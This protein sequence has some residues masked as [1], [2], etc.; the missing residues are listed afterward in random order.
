MATGPLGYLS[1]LLHGH[2]P[3][4][5]HPE[6]ED[7]L[8][9]RWLVE[10]LIECY[11]PL[12]AMLEGRAGRRAGGRIT[13]SLSPTL[14][15][16][17]ADPLLKE[18]LV[19]RVERLLDLA[20]ADVARYRDDARI[21]PLAVFYRDRF[22]AGLSQFAER[23]GRDVISAFRE[24]ESAGV[25]RLVTCG[26]THGFL[27]L[28]DLGAPSWRAQIGTAVREFE[29]LVGHAPEGFWLPECGYTPGVE[30]VLAEFGVRWFVVDT[31]GI[32]DACPRPIPGTYAPLR[33]ASG[34][35]ALGRDA[36]SSRQVWSS[37][38]GYPGDSWYREYYRD[39]GFDLPLETVRPYLP[40]GGTR[41]HLGL[42][43]YRITDRRYPHRE[44]YEPARAAERVR[45]HARHFVE[46]RIAQARGAAE[47][48]GQ[49]AFLL[50]PYDAEL[51]GHWWFEGPD[52]LDQV[53]DRVAE[54]P[55]LEA[56]DPLDAARALRRHSE[57][58]IHPCSW[59]ENGYASFWLDPVNDWIYRHLLRS[60]E[61]MQAAARIGDEGSPLR[62]RALKQ[63]GREL[64]LAQASDWAF[65]M[66]TGTI[67]PYAVKRTEDHL[68]RFDRLARMLETR[69]LEE[70]EVAA[71]E[72][73]DPVF[74]RID[75]G[76]FA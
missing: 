64:L 7:P 37:T 62:G 44:P 36:E 67:V 70:A 74:P 39:Q 55:E 3:F 68:E 72:E 20:E 27:P 49:P 71:I 52:W 31:H 43:Y 56:V 48:L 73:V 11:L 10:A 50:A 65:I 15:A 26:A 1:I 66:K 12:L 30:A 61:R 35:L 18:R 75:P 41:T 51:Y 47:A 32:L 58:Q 8:E 45:D 28:M 23:Y 13:I 76:L 17:L 2:L 24:V 69:I 60:A 6:F 63:A 38:E 5:R 46:G 59:G 42:K 4:V 9:E 40:S 14:L 22:R 33:T 29:R 34:V 53:L 16:M 19:H 54:R 21:G 57:G 25:V